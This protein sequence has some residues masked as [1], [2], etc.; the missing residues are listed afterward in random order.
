MAIGW[1]SALKIIPWKDVI[2][3]APAVVMGA[4]QLWQSIR[5]DNTA[6]T[7]P[8]QIPDA[9]AHPVANLQARVALLEKERTQAQANALEAAQLVNAMAEQ[10]QRLVEVV[11]KLRTR[12]RILICACVVLFLMLL[13]L[14]LWS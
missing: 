1:L 13:K 10:H 7:P 9:S 8:E 6:P 11:D 5:K 4:R 2:Q 3:A 12:S 14:L